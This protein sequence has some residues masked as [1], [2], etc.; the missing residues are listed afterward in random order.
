M[1]A[2][3][4]F[5]HRDCPDRIKPLLKKTLIDLI[6]NHDVDLFYVGQQ[7]AFD[8]M[9]YFVL[10]EMK[11]VYPHIRYTVVFDQIPEKQ[12]EMYPFDSSETLFPEGMEKVHPR[13][14]ISRRNQWMLKR[15]SFVIS[16]ITHSW[17]GA[18]KF[19]E[20]AKK[21]KKTVI[22]LSCE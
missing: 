20:M 6:E 4:F 3:T 17:G 18:A 7:G 1:P 19:A 9:V 16:Y 10:K 12:D 8:A 5:G 2:C 21:Q 11:E 15:S 22:N 13:F 14:R